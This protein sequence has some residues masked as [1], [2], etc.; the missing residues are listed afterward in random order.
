MSQPRLR[1]S[2]LEAPFR[3]ARV[4]ATDSP[5]EL[6]ERCRAYRQIMAPDA[7]FSHGTAARLLQLPLPASV[8][9]DPLIDVAVIAPA[10]APRMRG[11]R[12]HQLVVAPRPYVVR[13][14]PI[15]HPAKVW[16]Q[17]SRRL[18][19]DALVVVGDSLVRRKEPL[20]DPVELRAAVARADGRPGIR[21]LRSAIDL[22]RARTDSPMETRLRLAI[23]QD[24][25]PEPVVNYLIAGPER[26]YHLDLAYPHWRVA[27]EYDGDHHRTDRDQ[28]RLD[29]DRLWQIERL[30]WRIVRLNHSHVAGG[31]REALRRIRLA[32]P[33]P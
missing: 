16:C 17:L 5:T 8:E 26:A 9:A 24:G 30:G 32:L 7:V 12:G 22:V 10:R 1:R 29:V 28:Y 3:S 27:I 19:L 20:I 18:S 15:P 25:L 14:L 6:V 2:D 11:I 31:A 33:T 21:A 4:A 13:G 23:V